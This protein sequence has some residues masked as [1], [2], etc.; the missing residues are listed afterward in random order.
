MRELYRI[1]QEA[2]Q[3]AGYRV[4][5][6]GENN[7][8]SEETN[9]IL[10]MEEMNLIENG[11]AQYHATVTVELIND[12]SWE[13]NFRKISEVLASFMPMEDRSD[14][15]KELPD[16]T[17][18]MILLDSPVFSEMTVEVDEDTAEEV[19]SINVELYFEF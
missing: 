18:K 9:I 16:N 6:Y 14:D 2:L 3:D 10:T 19:N 4:G 17:D 8:P 7:P 1:L 11:F 5:D 12:N 15:L 13:D